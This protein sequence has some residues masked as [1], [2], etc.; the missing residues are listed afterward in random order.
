MKK[1][2]FLFVLMLSVIG[3]SQAQEKEIT[4]SAQE[5]Q[6]FMDDVT[7]S[8]KG[9]IKEFG[10]EYNPGTTIDHVYQLSEYEMRIEGMVNYTTKKSGD[11]RTKYRLNIIVEGSNTYAKPCIY[12]P[13]CFLGTVTEYQWD[14][15]GTKTLIEHYKKH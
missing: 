4:L 8:L 1:V 9:L 5:K 15:T 7:T 11:V 12:T 6:V 14:C 3:F 2:F 10:G 13:Y